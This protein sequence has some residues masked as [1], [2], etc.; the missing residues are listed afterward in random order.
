MPLRLKLYFKAGLT[1][2]AIYNK[3]IGSTQRRLDEI[4][5]MIRIRTNKIKQSQTCYLKNVELYLR[6][7]FENTL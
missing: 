7:Y 5:I 6:I 2:V 3:K 1:H 4:T